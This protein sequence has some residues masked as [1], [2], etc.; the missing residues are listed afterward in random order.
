M[1]S[2]C[3]DITSKIYS[4]NYN[5][6]Y[7]LYGN[8][9]VMDQKAGLVTSWADT[10]Y[11]DPSVLPGVGPLIAHVTTMARADTSVYLTGIDC[12]CTGV[13]WI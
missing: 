5:G 11:P 1:C 8:T 6:I 12:A 13:W 7:T 9:V 10:L 4:D 3:A 2:K